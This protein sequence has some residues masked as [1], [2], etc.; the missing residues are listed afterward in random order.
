[1][2]FG[3][4]LYSSK[5]KTLYANIALSTKHYAEN[6]YLQNFNQIKSNTHPK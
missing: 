5:L 4:D 1:M 3:N 6:N 2:I